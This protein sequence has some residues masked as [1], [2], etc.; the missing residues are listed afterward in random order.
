MKTL[1]FLASFVMCAGLLWGM[2]ARGAQESQYMVL[3]ISSGSNSYGSL[4]KITLDPTNPPSPNE[5]RYKFQSEHNTAIIVDY[6]QKFVGLIPPKSVVFNYDC[7]RNTRLELQ[8]SEMITF[9]VG[10]ESH[11]VNPFSIKREYSQDWDQIILP[12][13]MIYSGAVTRYS[14]NTSSPFNPF[15]SKSYHPCFNFE[16][17]LSNSISLRDLAD[18]MPT[19]IFLAEDAMN[20]RIGNNGNDAINQFKE[21]FEEQFNAQLL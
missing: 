3:G 18:K 21:A 12:P 15:H 8:F 9:T 14:R 20:R 13:N 11:A 1:K 6:H 7:H 4:G 10:I 19:M 17:Q 2:D 16:F 5:I